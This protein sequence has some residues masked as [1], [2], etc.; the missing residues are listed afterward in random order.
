[1]SVIVEHLADP[2]DVL[3]QRYAGEGLAYLD[4]DLVRGDDNER[5][6]QPWQRDDELAHAVVFRT[7]GGRIS[8]GASGSASP[9]I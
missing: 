7:D 1:M 8:R 6:I 5:G 2:I 4:A 3:A 9:S